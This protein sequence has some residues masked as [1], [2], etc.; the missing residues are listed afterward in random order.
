MLTTNA[1]NQICANDGLKF[2]KISSGNGL[3]K[4]ML[5]VSN[6][7]CANDGLKF[8]KISLG[9]GLG[10]HMLDISTFPAKT[11]LTSIDSLQ[12]YANWLIQ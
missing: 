1:L 10:K 12:A 5:D 6:Q 8:T 11:M 3:G 9:N 7:I 2:M 4:H